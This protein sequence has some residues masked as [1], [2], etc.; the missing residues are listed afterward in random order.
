MR[1]RNKQQLEWNEDES[2]GEDDDP[3][4]NNKTS[5]PEDPLKLS[6]AIYSRETVETVNILDPKQI[7]YELILRLLERLCLEENSIYSQAI[8]VF[9]PG[10]AEI[11]KL[12]EMLNDHE[13]FGREDDFRLYALHSSISSENQSAVFDVPPHGV[14][15]IVL[16]SNIAE[17]GVT[18]PGGSGI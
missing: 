11:K 16:S 8:L 12:N 7:P 17:T 1:R 2:A 9:L 10:I 15:K 18:I 5:T 3:D 13:R 14:R 6:S 4:D